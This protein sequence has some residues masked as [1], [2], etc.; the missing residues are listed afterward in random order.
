MLK[1]HFKLALRRLLRNKLYT[2]ANLLGLSIGFAS[3][4]II[5]LF[6]RKEQSFD[7]FHENSKNI[8]RLL[9]T[10]ELATGS[11]I[12]NSVTAPLAPFISQ[13]YPEVEASTRYRFSGSMILGDSLT[14]TKK[15]VRLS[16]LIA[17]TDFFEVFTFKLIAGEYPDFEE[18]AKATVITESKAEA[19]FGSTI[20]ALNETITLSRDDYRVVGVI[21]DVPLNSSI[22]FDVVTSLVDANSSFPVMLTNWNTAWTNTVVRFGERV[23][24]KQ[25]D[26]VLSGLKKEY[27]L[28]VNNSS[29]ISFQWQPLHRFHFDIVVADGI[30]GKID[31]SYLVIFSAVA[32]IILIS[33]MS[34]YCSLTL[35]QSVERVKEIGVRRT[36]GAKRGELLLNY[37][38]ESLLLTSLA[39]VFGL[40]IS[41]L[42]I[43]QLEALFNRDLGIPL[44]SDPDVLIAAYG[45]AV[46]LA[47]I[48]VTYP[49]LIVSKK[50]LSDLR[51]TSGLSLFNKSVFIDVINGFQVAVF[52]F[53]IA[54]TLFVSRQ[55]EFIQHENLG[56]NKENVVIVNVNTRESVLNKDAIKSEFAKSPYVQS[57][58]FAI[59]YPSVVGA[60]HYSDRA[61]M[62]YMEYKIESGYLDVLGLELVQGRPLEDL[63]HHKRYTIINESAANRLGGDQAIGK[64]LNGREII[65]I[66]RDFHMESKQE[67]IRPLALR[68]FDSGGFG[69][70]IVKLKDGNVKA[71]LDDLSNRYDG[72]TGSTKFTYTFLDDDYSRIYSSEMVILRMM[73]VFTI[74]A[75]FIAILGVLGSSAYTVKRRMKEISIR[76]VLGANILNISKTINSKAVIIV[77]FSAIVALPLSYMWTEVWL[78]DF[79]YHVK[80]TLWSFLV[81]FAA[82]VLIIFPA[83]TFHVINAFLSNTLKHLKE[84]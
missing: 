2:L 48:S 19:I 51:G 63:E 70:I 26:Y 34:N 58:S 77:F 28:Q 22:K 65:G 60:T 18:D 50:H 67:P 21:Q 42:A 36:I 55:F 15:E 75:L 24:D 6:V 69:R 52:L 83:T 38:V 32:L 44:F 27:N 5:F 72:V 84:E 71:A 12:S 3:V 33:S 66:V 57:L 23:T 61:E 59:G 17:D 11:E 41:E 20:N 45:V 76:K 68:L 40:I 7:K 39:F 54:S 73:S 53:L 64:T 31:P 8:Y 56:F 1:V 43:P 82:A 9:S 47:I 25:M 37:F 16:R 10:K 74:M 35:S 4:L 62:N 79:A 29:N 81:V 78:S 46:I 80:V 14:A 49:A 30:L 13:H